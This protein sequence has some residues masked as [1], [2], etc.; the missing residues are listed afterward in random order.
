M[1][2]LPRFPLGPAGLLPACQGKEFAVPAVA[3]LSSG[4]TH[5]LCTAGGGKASAAVEKSG[6]KA[7]LGILCTAKGFWWNQS[8]AHMLFEKM[9]EFFM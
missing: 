4:M 1:E 3:W 9:E 5:T 2:D 8:S 7:K 6:S